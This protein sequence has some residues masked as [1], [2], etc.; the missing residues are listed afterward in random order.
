MRL[1]YIYDME[2]IS[3]E[4]PAYEWK[5]LLLLCCLHLQVPIEGGF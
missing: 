4:E 1:K 2:L 3:Y 5:L